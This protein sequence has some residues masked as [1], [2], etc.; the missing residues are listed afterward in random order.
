M[1][2]GARERSIPSM[3]EYVRDS[4]RGTGLPKAG[5]SAKK[6][7]SKKLTMRVGRSQRRLHVVRG[8][9]LA[10]PSKWPTASGKQ[11][12]SDFRRLASPFGSGDSRRDEICMESS[13]AASEHHV[14]LRN[15]THLESIICRALPF[16]KQL[17]WL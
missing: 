11:Q 4:L 3:L 13:I 16:C 10:T 9:G 17:H 5:P 6:R 7:R 15:W 1:R 12:R 2:I 8:Q 14:Y